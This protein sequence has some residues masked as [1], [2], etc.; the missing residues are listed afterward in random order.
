MKKY[1]NKSSGFTL[2]ELLV[3]IA[4]IGI[5][6]GIVLTSLSSARNKANDAKIISQLGQIRSAAELNFNPNDGQG[7]W[8][9]A[10]STQTCGNAAAPTTPPTVAPLFKKPE[11]VKLIS[12]T[13][14]LSSGGTYCNV[15]P[16]SG[17]ARASWLFGATLVSDTSKTWCVDSSGNSK[18]ITPG[19]IFNT[20]MTVCP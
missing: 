13:A 1:L 6:A 20:A 16:A 4:I 8:G 5:L 15:I 3:V 14:A 7:G 10:G 11:L 12:S 9:Q 19:T 18:L 17:T 2:I